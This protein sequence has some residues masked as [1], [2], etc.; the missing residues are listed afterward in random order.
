MFKK[1]ALP[2]VVAFSIGAFAGYKFLESLG[3]QA[4]INAI[5]IPEGSLADKDAF[6]EVLPEG[7]PLIQKDLES[8]ERKASNIILLIGDGM[9]ISQISSYRLLKGG[10]NEKNISR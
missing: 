7:A 2:V 4:L 6:I 9:S 10:P 5:P 8:V 1:Y 3:M